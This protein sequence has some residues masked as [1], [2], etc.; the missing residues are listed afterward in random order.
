MKR[1]LL[2]L[3]ALMAL[4]VEG[5]TLTPGY[6]FGSSETVTAAK[7]ASLVSSAS[8]S[9]ITGADFSDGAVTNAKLGSDAVT[10]DKILDGTIT[11]SD[12]LS[13]TLTSS[14]YGTNSVDGVAIAT[15]IQ[16]RAGT[17]LIV[18]NAGTAINF[19]NATLGFSA[20]QIPASAITGIVTNRSNT[21][22]TNFNGY[23]YSS[24][25]GYTWSTVATLTTTATTG[26]VT[27]IGRMTIAPS[28]A[29]TTMLRVVDSG[30]TV[31]GDDGGTPIS[32]SNCTPYT[33]RLVDFLTGTT[34][35]YTMQVATSATSTTFTNG[36]AGG[37][38]SAFS[39]SN[40][41][42]MVIQQIP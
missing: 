19:T 13:R 41:L 1:I 4:R 27:V 36:I 2:L 33:A 28:Q 24:G 22:T 37:A 30:G 40:G 31:E 32:G 7:L 26:S 34:K 10:T 6:S 12:I 17:F 39:V 23:T 21:I 42:G 14:I 20:G 9:G 8:I 38:G 25:A 29:H 16:L 35:T 15:N 18:T 3:I 11:A 5:A